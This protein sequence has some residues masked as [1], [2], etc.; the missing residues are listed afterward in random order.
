M[1]IGKELSKKEK[2]IGYQENKDRKGGEPFG[3]YF[4]EVEGET[5]K[6]EDWTMLG[7]KNYRFLLE[8]TKDK[9]ATKGD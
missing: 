9:V 5:Q 2:L 7:G 8:P 3:W 6:I 1:S 4:A